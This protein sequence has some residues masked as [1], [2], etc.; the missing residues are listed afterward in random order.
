MCTWFSFKDI[1]AHQW[2]VLSIELR[3][4]LSISYSENFKKNGKFYQSSIPSL[5]YTLCIKLTWNSL[6]LFWKCCHQLPKMGRLK[7]SRPLIRVLVFNDNIYGLTIS[8]E[9]L[10]V[11]LVHENVC[12]SWCHE[13]NWR[14]YW[15]FS[16]R[17]RYMIGLFLF[18]SVMRC[19][20]VEIWPD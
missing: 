20:V 10:Y 2:G 12:M 15:W 16:S 19:L 5:P 7:A 3:W 6:S 11:R 14:W 9:N 1:Y 17:Q 4:N 18:L 8:W 13:R